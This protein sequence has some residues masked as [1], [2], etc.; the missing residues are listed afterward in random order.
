MLRS[1]IPILL[2]FAWLLPSLARADTPPSAPLQLAKFNGENKLQCLQTARVPAAASHAIVQAQCTP[3][4]ALQMFR[5]ESVGSGVYTIRNAQTGGCLE[6]EAGATWP[7]GRILDR[8]C[9]GEDHQR[10]EVN[11]PGSFPSVTKI[12]S[13][14]SK[15]CLDF[16]EGI[17]V[18]VACDWEDFF[19]GPI[20]LANRQH[21]R[22]PSGEVWARNE[23]HGLCMTTDQH[24]VMRACSEQSSWLDLRFSAIDDASMTFEMWST[25]P[26]FC[27]VD[28]YGGFAVYMQC[29]GNAA[30]TWRLVQRMPDFGLPIGAAANRWQFQN[31]ATGL[32]LDGSHQGL[33]QTKPCA[34]T[35]NVTWSFLTP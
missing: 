16:Q 12:R 24:P 18:Q 4:G 7:G 11:Y 30:S 2:S 19:D 14:S 1:L 3:A 28:T 23:Q 35:P 21:L 33:V 8:T 15:L 6:V 31:V 5:F 13:W 9:S 26:D 27:L 10:W 17:A 29:P 25:R 22:V 20:W 34:G 32:C